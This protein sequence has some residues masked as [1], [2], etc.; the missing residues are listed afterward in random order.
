MLSVGAK[1]PAV[2]HSGAADRRSVLV[3]LPAE[4]AEELLAGLLRFGEQT[5]ALSDQGA[6]VLV[7]WSARGAVECPFT[8]VADDGAAE[9]ARAYGVDT[10]PAVFAIDEAGIVRNVYEAERYPN[11][12]NPAAVVRGLRKLNDAPRP[13]AVEPADWRQGPAG[14]AVTLIEYSDYQCGHCHDLH[15]A[16]E[17]VLRDFADRVR[18]GAPSPAAACDAP[19]GAASRGGG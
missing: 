7:I 11:L 8:R 16:L 17:P 1:A 6:D 19:I 4:P 14:A 12:P 9:L 3:F 10:P 5:Q 2:G 18:N 13:A 15:V